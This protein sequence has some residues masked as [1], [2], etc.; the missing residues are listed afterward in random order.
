MS[1]LGRFLQRATIHPKWISLLDTFDLVGARSLSWELSGIIRIRSDMVGLR[2]RVAARD[3][4]RKA[5]A[6]CS[7]LLILELRLGNQHALRCYL[8]FGQSVTNRCSPHFLPNAPTDLVG[9]LST[10][11]PWLKST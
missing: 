9:S 1:A 11:R 2:P 8:P 5:D 3:G 6:A 10:V 4:L 7:H